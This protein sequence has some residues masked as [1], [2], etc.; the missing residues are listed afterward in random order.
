M[1]P[2]S[3]PG[4][5]NVQVYKPGKP[6][7]ELERE[8]GIRHALKLASNENPY[9]PSPKALAA[10]KSALKNAHRYPDGSCF[11]LKRALAERFGVAE[12]GIVVGNGSDELIVMAIR[13]FVG[14]G[15]E[16][17]TATPTFLIYRIATLVQGAKIVEVPQKDFKYDL[18]AMT[19]AITPQT[20]A[21]FIANPDN[22]TGSFARRAELEAFVKKVPSNCLIFMDEAYYEYAAAE[23]DYPNT[24]AWLSQ[25]P[26]LIVSRTFS[27]AY[28]LCGL[29]VGYAFA[30]P[31]VAAGMNRVRE[32]FNVNGPAQAAACA[33]LN[34]KAFVKKIVRQTVS[35][36]RRLEAQ[37]RQRGIRTVPSAA[38]FILMHLGAAA[39]AVYEGLLRKGVIVRHM[40]SWG[41]EEHIRVTV[42]RPQDNRVFLKALDA[43]LSPKKK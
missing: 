19:A 37:L 14:S 25:R 41:L 23:K 33:A 17:L 15:E 38:N 13:A 12:D 10:A 3:H 40:K 34:D 7:E 31:E 4:L 5:E 1:F 32:P 30:H 24:I 18:K 28:G 9:G 16:V 27:K 26:N 36:R 11:Y 35:E 42:G 22:P 21:I 20:K 29:R 2:F 39:P 8:L 6:V 43:S